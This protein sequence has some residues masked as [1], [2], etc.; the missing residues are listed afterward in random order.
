MFFRGT[1][2]QEVPSR[3]LERNVVRADSDV[4]FFVTNAVVLPVADRADFVRVGWCSIA[5]L[6]LVTLNCSIATAEAVV[7]RGLFGVSCFH[8]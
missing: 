3:L 2:L 5:Q 4:G 1:E 8:S 6:R 7:K